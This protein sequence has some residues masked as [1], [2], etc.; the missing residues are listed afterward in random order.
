M[1]RQDRQWSASRPQEL[2]PDPQPQ[3]L[4][5]AGSEDLGSDRRLFSPVLQKYPAARPVCR[6]CPCTLGSRS[7]EQ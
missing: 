5:G 1:P 3:A 7:Q 4:P 6:L 2:L